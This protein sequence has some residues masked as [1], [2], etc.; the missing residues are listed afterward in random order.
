MIVLKDHQGAEWHAYVYYSDEARQVG[1]IEVYNDSTG[2]FETHQQFEW[3]RMTQV[4]LKQLKYAHPRKPGERPEFDYY[5]PS[6]MG[7]SKCSHLDQFNK[8]RGRKMALMRAVKR[9]FPNRHR[10]EGL[11]ARRAMWESYING[12]PKDLAA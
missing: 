5:E 10:G 8:R 9:A 12:H 2:D 3:E 1:T 4:E 7:H 11:A 6:F